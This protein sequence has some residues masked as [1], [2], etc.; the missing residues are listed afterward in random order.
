MPDPC[1]ELRTVATVALLF[2]A[3]CADSDPSPHAS[4]GTAEGTGTIAS[5]SD[6]DASDGSTGASSGTT[7]EGRTSSSG[8]DTT[9]DG[10]TGVEIQGCGLQDLKPGAPDPIV[11]G[12]GAMDIPSDVATVLSANCGCHL[13]D[14]LTVDGVPDYTSKGAFDLT[15]YAGFQAL[16]SSDKMP[17]YDIAAEYL[18]IDFM[19]LTSFCHVG[20]GD[21]MPPAD[22]ALLK[23]WLD[24]DAPDG[25]NWMP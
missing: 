2:A 19:P 25:A 3:A 22:R 21:A 14:D 6:T 4:G 7:S 9:A 5:S 23:A 10:T 8:G 16:R 11:A 15:T 18:D 1:S 12:R 17:Y 24:A 20:N 13:A